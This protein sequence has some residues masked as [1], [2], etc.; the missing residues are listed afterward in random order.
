[1]SVAVGGT[2][3]S[4]GVTGVAVGGTAVAVGGTAVALAVLVM[5]GVGVLVATEGVWVASVPVGVLVKVPETTITTVTLPPKGFPW[6]SASLQY[7]LNV[8]AVVG[9][10]RETDT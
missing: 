9:A 1:M 8:P 6:L 7:P 3:V 2:E 4:V 5:I 10:V